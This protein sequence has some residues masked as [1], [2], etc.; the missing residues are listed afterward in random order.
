GSDR[1]PRSAANLPSVGASARRAL[2]A[3]TETNDIRQGHELRRVT[4]AMLLGVDVGTTNLKV[5][6]YAAERGEVVAVARRPT[7]MDRPR[8]GWAEFSAD[9]LWLDTAIA[10]REIMDRVGPTRVD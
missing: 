1:I 10:L 5:V 9:E 7:R 8:P 6:A 3:Y 2:V 4:R